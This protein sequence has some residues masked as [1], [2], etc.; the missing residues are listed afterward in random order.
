V[1]ELKVNL[2]KFIVVYVET[3][4]LG[5]LPLVDSSPYQVVSWPYNR[6]CDKPDYETLKKFKQLT[7]P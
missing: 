1:A 6:T 3:L 5:R 2:S 4:T 7:Q